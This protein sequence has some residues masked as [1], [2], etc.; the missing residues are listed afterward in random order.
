MIKKFVAFLIIPFLLFPIFTCFSSTP[1]YAADKKV[2]HTSKKFTVK[3]NKK[4]KSFYAR[5]VYNKTK[6]SCGT[7]YYLNSNKKKVTN[8]ST[9]KTINN[10]KNGKAANKEV[11]DWCKKQKNSNSGGNNNNNNNNNN[12]GGGGGTT[13]TTTAGNGDVCS[14]NVAESV[15]AANGCDGTYAGDDSLP[16]VVAN[17]IEAII[18]LSGLVAVVFIVIG[19]IQYMSA[20]GDPSK[21]TKAKNTIL[22]ACIGLTVCALAFAIVNFVINDIL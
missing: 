21:I 8:K 14:A 20:T 9:L 3:V 12:N 6:N 17:I 10:S 7:P 13:G 11:T 22:Y 1:T 18:S 4:N 16:R 19:G 15:K 2:T 5:I